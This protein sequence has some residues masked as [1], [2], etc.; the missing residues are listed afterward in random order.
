MQVKKK[1][2]EQLGQPAKAEKQEKKQQ[3]P[4]KEEDD[5]LM[6]TDDMPLPISDTDSN[7]GWKV[8]KKKCI[9]NKK[10]TK[11]TPRKR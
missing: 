10:P 4:Q 1:K 5:K 6:D 3:E 7:D 11:S 2:L 9:M 8:T